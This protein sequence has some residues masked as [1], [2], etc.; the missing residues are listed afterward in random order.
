MEPQEEG[1]FT[2]SGSPLVGAVASKI[3]EMIRSGLLAE[4]QGLPSERKLST[5]FSVSRGV[6]RAAIRELT[7]AGLLESKPRCRPI[8]RPVRVAAYTGRSHICIWLWPGISDYSSA[9]TLNGIQS[10]ALGADMRLVIG[11]ASG[12]DWDSR[13]DSEGDFLG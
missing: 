3:T 11:H 4:G 9:S 12:L 5:D 6:V 2:R 10:T 7:K 13:L 1:A 8:V